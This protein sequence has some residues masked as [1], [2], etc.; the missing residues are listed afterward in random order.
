MNTTP[1]ARR[2]LAAATLA[3]IVLAPVAPRAWG[4]QGHRLVALIAAERLTPVAKQNVEWLLGPESLA[5]VSSWADQYLQGN[6]QTFYWHFINIPPDATSYNRDRDCLL[7]PTVAA[8]SYNDKWRDCVIERISY[9][10]ERVANTSLDRADR[11]IAL[12]FLV[13]F[14]GDIHQPFHSFGV[15]H[16]ANDVHVNVFGAD[17]CGG[18]TDRQTPCNLHSVWDSTMIGRRSMDDTAFLKVL[19]DK[20]RANKWD[21][22]PV[23][24]PTDWAMESHTFAKEAL[25]P[26]HGVIDQAYYEKHIPVID[27]R[28]A[29]AGLRLGILINRSLTTPPPAR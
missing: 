18:N 22:Q 29:Q 28:L 27:Q 5:D 6:Y 24:T 23:G 17:T 8:G 13:H 15:G 1:I 26:M 2:M 21:S 19:K 25:V 11:A 9:N 20:I 3:A 4:A 16:G 7:Q 12:K 10:E 14:V